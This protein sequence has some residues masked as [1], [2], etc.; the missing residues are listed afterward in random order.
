M[1]SYYV[2]NKIVLPVRVSYKCEYCQH[3]NL[4]NTQRLS[5]QGVSYS[6]PLGVNHTMQFQA[7]ERV[8]KEFSSIIN[9]LE[10]RNYLKANLTCKC[11]NCGKRQKWSSFIIK[12]LLATEVVF[13][14]GIVS[15]IGS[16]IH[17]II[18]S[19]SNSFASNN[20]DWLFLIISIV[21]ILPYPFIHLI[22][23]AK[24]AK[25]S[26]LSEEYHPHFAITNNGTTYKSLF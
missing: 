7:S 10:N 24:Q 16:I 25:I 2:K 13:I 9:E 8:N 6:S 18:N 17:F 14:L 12:P 3:Q 11:S 23:N 19:I 1:K 26:S 15:F 20:I 22:N 21:A 5:A 4:D